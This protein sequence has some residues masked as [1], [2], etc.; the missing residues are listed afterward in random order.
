MRFCRVAFS[1]HNY[2]RSQGNPLDE[3]CDL[4][5]ERNGLAVCFP[6]GDASVRTIPMLMK[7]F[8]TRFAVLTLLIAISLLCQSPLSAQGPKPPTTP[9]KTVEAAPASLPSSGAHELTA[10]DL[11]AFLDGLM[12]LQLQRE[13]I[14]GAVVLVVKDGKVLFAKGYGYS[15]V[16]KKTPVTSDATLF[17]PGSV[18][19]LFTWTS[20]MQMV[21]QGKLDLD[22][23]VNDYLDFKI[24]PR[25]GKPITLRNIMTHTSGM[26]ESVQ[27]LFIPDAKDLVSLDVYVKEHLP[28][29]IFAP[30]T[31]PAYSN[32]A[33]TLAGYI[34]QRVSGQP[35]DDYVE[36][37]IFNPLKMEHTTFRQPLPAALAPMM[38]KGYSVASQ[39]AKPF[40]VVQAFPAGSVSTTAA[41]MAHFMI[42]HLQNGQYEGAQILKPETAKL[43]HSVAFQ[44]LPQLP[45]M[46]LGFYE[47][48]RNGHRIIAHAGDTEA[49]HS[50]LHL[51][52]D[53]N[54][55]FF[56]SYNSAG[57]GE[58][59]PREALFH[60]FLDRYL[61]YQVPDTPALATAKADAEKV[62][63]RYLVSRRGETTLFWV[64]NAIGQT[65][66]TANPDGT[67]SASGMNG[68]N[69][70]PIKFRE[71]APMLFRDVDG[72][73][74]LGFKHDQDSGRD[75][76]A[77]DFPFMVFEKDHWYE[78]SSLS[79]F[80]IIASLAVFVLTL[81]FWPVGGFIR[82]HY[83]RKLELGPR[84]RQVRFV[85]RLVC[86]LNLAMVLGF[87]I[88]FS[89]AM[90]D[91]GMMSPKY[92]GWLR[93]FQLFG[94]LGVIG[95]LVAV[96]NVLRSWTTPGRWLW[97]KL[98]DA[99]IALACIG[100]AWYAL[101]WNLLNLNLRY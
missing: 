86:I 6:A 42:A 64:L 81:V 13:D 96:Y 39:P 2:A 7:S 27:Q 55:G 89:I 37:H 72:Q 35:F 3:L 75:I 71:I 79:N 11:E 58:T 34:V 18:S 78:S 9:K 22:R 30:G 15:D 73:E 88:F 26:E 45:G 76:M 50:D 47:E 32:Y 87:V 67:I 48:M 57:K 46:C 20:V 93:L 63:G 14:A 101:F 41:D 100:F 43:M 99:V 49:F 40:E 84:E 52:L 17:R 62:V 65:K 16:A 23:D 33:T 24:P 82:R 80:I 90:K 51:I 25:D 1:N 94:W 38:S 4:K 53:S 95:T 28:N 69:G 85:V 56:V 44:N 10:T 5:A 36:Q 59:R 91:I 12:P 8:T 77:I 97:S 54:V 60:A 70:K 31:L 92:N 66:V 74:M 21:E 83:G 98:G 19:K 29:R 61:P 68:A